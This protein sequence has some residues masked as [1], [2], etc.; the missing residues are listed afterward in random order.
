MKL[1][2]YLEKRDFFKLPVAKKVISEKK[3]SRV[4]LK[5][6]TV[7]K[8]CNFFLVHEK[9]PLGSINKIFT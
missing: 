7:Q 2:F 8:D 3:M 5:I 4:V 9:E 1:I 6:V